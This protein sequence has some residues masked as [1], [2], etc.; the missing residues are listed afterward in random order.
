MNQLSLYSYI[1]PK[2]MEDLYEQARHVQG[3]A[4]L[5]AGGTDLIIALK[6]KR[7]KP[8]TVINIKQ[9]KE[10][11]G[12]KLKDNYLSVGA[13]TTLYEVCRSQLI[14]DKVSVLAQAAR[15]V[16]TP[17]IRNLG[18]IGG[19]LCL[20]TRCWNF[21]QSAFWRQAKGDCLKSGGLQCFVAKRSNQCVAAYSGDLAP[22]LIAL[23][24]KVK[25]THLL[26]KEELIIPLKDL[27]TGK[28]KNPINL[29]DK[30]LLQEI[31]IPAENFTCWGDYHKVSNREVIDF[32]II[33]IAV[34]LNIN[35]EKVCT[36]VSIVLTGVETA[37][38]ELTDINN[39]LLGNKLEDKLIYEAAETAAKNLKIFK[40]SSASVSYKKSLVAVTLKNILI[41][42]RQQLN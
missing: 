35:E 34:V 21:N 30:Q 39:K 27:Y 10:L 11:K 37:P 23:G 29:T 20:N 26:T 22:V 4:T 18:T 24:A 13:L 12:I 42:A 9:I 16:A 15:K 8:D 19:N 36:K 41:K 31:I 5:Y 28:G 7:L 1:S 38:C 32:P 2:N 3:N 14:N 6:Q 17:L 33:G 25:L 40:T